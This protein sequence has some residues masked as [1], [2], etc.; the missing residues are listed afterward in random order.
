MRTA[1]FGSPRLAVFDSDRR[2]SIVPSASAASRAIAGATGS[3]N[4]SATCSAACRSSSS[5]ATIPAKAMVD[6]ALQRRGLW[7]YPAYITSTNG[8][9]TYRCAVDPAEHA[10]F[11]QADAI[12]A[13]GMPHVFASRLQMRRAAAGAR[14][15]HRPVLR[16]GARSRARAAPRCS[17]SAP[18]R[19]RTRSR[20]D[21]RQTD[22]PDCGWSA[23]ATATSPMRKRRSRSAARSPSSAPDILWV[24]MGVPREQM[25]IGPQPLTAHHRR[26]HQDLRRTVR[27]PVGIE[28]ARAAVDAARRPRMA[29]ADRARAAP[30]RLALSE[31]QSLRDVSAADEDAVIRRTDRFRY[32][33][34]CPGHD[35]QGL[36]RLTCSTC[37]AETAF[38]R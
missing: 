15:H 17:C 19:P 36:Q 22:S 37:A 28:A 16:R 25:F 7:R 38:R 3:S 11:L 5:T 4:G 23:A 27:F 24:S 2:P 26:R 30:A 14:R 6:E 10:M 12:H 35:G 21:R 33:R 13:D 32:G 9:V 20:G 34:A 18:P 29:V 1:E 31:D 8:E